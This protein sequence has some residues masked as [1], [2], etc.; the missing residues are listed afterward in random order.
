[1]KSESEYMIWFQTSS[2]NNNYL[3]MSDEEVSH[4]LCWSMTSRAKN[5]VLDHEFSMHTGTKF[6]PNPPCGFVEETENVESHIHVPHHYVILKL[7]FLI[8]F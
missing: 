6:H 5:L 7:K 4:K 3:W 2:N 8:E 1:M